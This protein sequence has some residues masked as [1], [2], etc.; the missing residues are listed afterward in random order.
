MRSFCPLTSPRHSFYFAVSICVRMMEVKGEDLLRQSLVV[1]L[2]LADLTRPGAFD[3]CAASQLTFYDRTFPR[4]WLVFQP[5]ITL[6][7]L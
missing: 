7:L 5:A 4:Q 2:L 3:Y 6:A 1:S